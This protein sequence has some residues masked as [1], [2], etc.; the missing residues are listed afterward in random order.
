[1]DLPDVFPDANGFVWRR[2]AR[3]KQ[4]RGTYPEDRMS[5]TAEPSGDLLRTLESEVEVEDRQDNDVVPSISRRRCAVS[6]LGAGV[7]KR[8]LP[9]LRQI[10]QQV[11]KSGFE[12]I[13]RR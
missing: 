9:F 6:G 1:M 8:L 12:F 7:L 4:A 3:G 11:G 5:E 10:V 13:E 2:R